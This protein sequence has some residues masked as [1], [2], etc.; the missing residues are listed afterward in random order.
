MDG[1]NRRVRRVIAFVE[2]PYRWIM[3]NSYLG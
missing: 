1:L 2:E 3:G